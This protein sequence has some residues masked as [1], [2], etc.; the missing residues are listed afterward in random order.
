MICNGSPGAV[1]FV[2]KDYKSIDLASIK[3]PTATNN[4]ATN[5]TYNLPAADAAALLGQYWVLVKTSCT[6]SG[7]GN[8]S[9]GPYWSNLAHFTVPLDVTGFKGDVATNNLDLSGQVDPPEGWAAVGGSI[10]IT[11]YTVDVYAESGQ[12]SGSG[13]SGVPVGS[14][15]EAG[16]TASA[17]ND[18]FSVDLP[19]GVIDLDSFKTPGDKFFL[20][21]Q[22]NI[23]GESPIDVRFQGGTFQASDGSVWVIG[24][25]SPDADTPETSQFTD[26]T[27]IDSVDDGRRTAGFRCSRP[28]PIP[29]EIRRP[30]GTPSI[31]DCGPVQRCTPLR[32]MA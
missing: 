13:L 3:N 23:A 12:V 17:N 27:T 32:T 14:Y 9:S 10:T 16:F 22:I 6:I 26:G 24:G 31:A 11:S 4:S 29:R 21:A 2:V 7:G 30:S 1:P 25:A 15:S 19:A 18:Q 28:L 8:K 20:F 5:Y